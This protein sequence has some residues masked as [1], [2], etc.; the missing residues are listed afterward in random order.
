MESKQKE[1]NEGRYYLK[2]PREILPLNCLHSTY[3]ASHVEYLQLNRPIYIPYHNY[4][5]LF[6]NLLCFVSSM[7]MI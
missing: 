3:Y 4:F 6:Q 1:I 2:Y 7:E 5:Q